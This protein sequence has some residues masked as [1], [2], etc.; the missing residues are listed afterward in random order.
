MKKNNK[1]ITLISLTIYVI[2]FIMVIGM[3]SIFKRNL[4][5]TLDDMGE[6]TSLVPEF[7]K[8]HMYMLDELSAADNKVVKR[9]SDGSY[10]E[11]SSGNSYLFSDNKIFKNNVK[12]FSNIDSCLFEVVKENNSDVLYVHISF[13]EY[14]VVYKEF[15]YVIGWIN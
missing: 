11:F 13:G 2:I 7:N 10:I 4:D 5:D 6:Y 1:G 9:N 14:D 3:L 8:V 12:I 15:K